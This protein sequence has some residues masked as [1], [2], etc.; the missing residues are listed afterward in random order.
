ME[1]AW[2]A[3]R[4]GEF[5]GHHL[6][7]ATH[8]PQYGI[9]V[10]ILPHERYSILNKIGQRSKLGEYLDQQLRAFLESSKYDL[11][12]SACQDN[13]LF[14]AILRDMGIFR[15]PI[16][17]I[18][19][20]PM[21]NGENDKIYV[22]GHDKLLC[23]SNS[24]LGELR[25]SFSTANG[26]TSVLDWGVDLPF[27][28]RETIASA[29]ESETSFII[30]TGRSVR[31]HDTLVKAFFNIDYPLKIYCSPQSAPSVSDLP[32]NVTVQGTHPFLKLR[33]E[34]KRAF[35]VAVPLIK[36]DLLAGL[37]SLLDAMA[38]RKPVIM[39]K[40]SRINF[41]IEKERIGIAV[42]V[43]DVQGWQNAVT[44]LL[45]HPEEANQMG[46]RGYLLCKNKY[47][48]EIFSSNLASIFKSL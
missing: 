35:A 25:S 41:D 17:S 27:Y 39:T 13:T 20:H 18:I 26:K 48:L 3:W 28:D 10:E 6:W 14:L 29:L 34:Y 44:Y 2:E 37:T 32:S 33:A 38:M 4:K 5:P 24:V 47:N 11:I 16:I 42:D 23:L 36:T 15:K 9:D 46:E 30:S 21:W 43:G 40:N 45:S 31:D 1:V 22:S 7:G 19:H 8:L 12:Y